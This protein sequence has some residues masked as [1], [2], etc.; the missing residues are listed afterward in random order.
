VN[1]EIGV[2]GH[3]HLNVTNVT[4]ISSSGKGT[5]ATLDAT[6]NTFLNGTTVGAGDTLAV[7]DADRL[8]VAGVIVPQEMIL[9]VPVTNTSLNNTIFIAN[10]AWQVTKIE[11]SLTAATTVYNPFP[12]VTIVKLT[13]AQV[14]SGNH[15]TLLGNYTRRL[16]FK[17]GS[18][19]TIATATLNS[20]VDSLQLA[21][22]DRLGIKSNSTLKDVV[23][24]ITIH[25]KRV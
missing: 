3:S 14:P 25:M 13:G 16:D 23:A 8:T 19:G 9:N 4:T 22:G 1:D 17:T 7:T 2:A 15:T 11:S 18:L 12:R 20:T 21:D 6:G 24:L 10:N 5:F